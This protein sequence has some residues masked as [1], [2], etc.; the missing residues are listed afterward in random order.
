MLRR[1]FFHSAAGCTPRRHGCY[2]LRPPRPEPSL[3]ATP[4]RASQRLDKAVL[5]ADEKT[6]AFIQAMA[7]DAVKY[8][9]DKVFV[10][11]DDKDYDPVTGAEAQVPDDAEDVVNN[12]L[13]AWRARRG[14]GRAPADQQGRQ[15]PR[16][17]GAGP[18]EGADESRAAADREARAGGRDQPVDQ[19]TARTGARA[20]TCSTA[21]DA[22]KRIDGR[23][24]AWAERK[25]P[26]TK[27]LLNQRLA[28]ETDA[29]V[30]SRHRGL[31]SHSIDGA[32]VWGDRINR[33]SSAVPA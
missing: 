21:A 8:T 27:L 6:A 11:K 14:A 32:L 13:H 18:A 1:P 7:D 17:R 30:K 22:A 5:T 31:A 4:R 28:D 2:A 15:G 23:Q 20:P 9:A 26:D 3:Q 19:G 12:N 33:G 10:I 25:S 16:R 24:G 29:G